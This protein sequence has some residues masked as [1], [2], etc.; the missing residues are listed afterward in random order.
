MANEYATLQ[1]L[2]ARLRVTANTDDVELQDKL[3]A[4]SQQIEEDCGRKF[5]LDS[6]ATARV[7]DPRERIVRLPFDPAEKLLVDDI[8][9]AT[10]LTVEVG[11]SAGWTAITDYRTGPDNA[12]ARGRPVTWLLRPLVPWVWGPVF[13]Q[14][15][16][17]TAIWGWPAVPAA[18]KEACLL[19][20]ARLYRRKASPEGVAGF[21]D[22][23]VVRVS[24]NDPDYESLIAP[25]VLESDG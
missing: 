9:D 1:E 20:A 6:Q 24:R 4:A 2:K 16:R 13:L 19:R 18:I 22:L 3:T 10:G 8:G 23:G 25:Y 17:V 15:I 7:Y 21:G 5:W 12:I 14:Q 11:T